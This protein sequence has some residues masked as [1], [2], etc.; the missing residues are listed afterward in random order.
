MPDPAATP[1]KP[2]SPIDG[3]ADRALFAPAAYVAGRWID[4]A[5]GRP[6]VGVSDPATG[7]TI[8]FVPVLG[9]DDATAA[10]DAAASAFPAWSGLLPQARAAYLRRWFELTMAARDDLAVILTREQGK[11]LKEARGEI[12]YA[13]SFIE[14][15]AEE[16]KR[17]NIESVTSHLAGAEVEVWREAAG[18]AALVTPWNFPAAM[19]TRKAVRGAR[20]RLHDRRPPL[21]ADAAHRDRAGRACRTRRHPRRRPQ[22]RHRRRRR[23][24]RPLDRRSA[25][26]GALL[27]RLHRDRPAALRPVGGHR[28]TAGAGARW[29]GPVHRF[30]RCR[31]RPGGRRSDQGQVLDLG[32]GLPRRQPHLCR[33]PGLRRLLSRFCRGHRGAHRRSRH[34]GPRHRPPDERKRGRQAMRA[35]RRRARAR[36]PLS[37]RRDCASRRSALLSADRTRRRAAQRAHHARGDLRAGRRDRALR[38]RSRGDR[39]APTIPST[40][41]SPTSTPTIPAASIG[42]AGRCNTAWSRSTAPRS[43]ARRSPSAV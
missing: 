1:I 9:A 31:S 3:L 6:E 37:H 24:R 32:P 34:G 28:E 43:P 7:E 13:A 4:A 35:G 42:R 8:A 10:V 27:H 5:S 15:Y 25:R 17:P 39:R 29:S 22:Y 41:S 21:H 36:R 30:R 18:V 14:F 16:A 26:A 11:P 2:A 23:D 38:R 40:A 33:A 19:L 20:C 12:D